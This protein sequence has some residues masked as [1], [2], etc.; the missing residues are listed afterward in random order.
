MRSPR[1]GTS[2]A[3]NLGLP[4][5][6]S[7]PCR[8]QK[9]S[10]GAAR[11]WRCPELLPSAKPP[12]AQVEHRLRPLGPI[13]LQPRP[14]LSL[15]SADLVSP[16]LFSPP[17]PPLS[18]PGRP[19]PPPRSPRRLPPPPASP[20]APREPRNWAQAPAGQK[21]RAAPPP[22]PRRPR[23]VPARSA[24]HRPP[25]PPEEEPRPPPWRGRRP[26]PRCPSARPPAPG[27]PAAASRPGPWPAPSHAPNS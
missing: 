21:K 19:R 27:P 2:P 5:R 17:G 24:W 8:L 25:P 3:T 7:V 4:S 23:R 18:C 12:L 10:H 14:T 11:P 20:P 26:A 16:P 22:A 9:R 13:G 15:G 6:P 1:P